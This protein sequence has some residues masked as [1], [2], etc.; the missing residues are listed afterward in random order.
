MHYIKLLRPPTLDRPSVSNNSRQHPPASSTSSVLKISLAITTDLGDA[1]LS[2]TT[3][4]ELLVIGAYTTTDKDGKP[5]L[6]PI[7][8]T[9]P[10]ARSNNSPK[11]KPGLRALKFEV[12]IP[13]TP[14][15]ITTVQ[16]RPVSREITALGTTDI[17]PIQKNGK[18]RGLIMPAFCD[19]SP[20]SQSSGQQSVCFRS[21]RLP[22]DNGQAIQVEEDMGDSIARHI[23]D[24]GIATVSLLADLCL[25]PH[26]TQDVMTGLRELLLLQ[27]RQ[28]LNILEIGCGIG[29]LGIGMARVMGHPSFPGTTSAAP[30]H[31]IL[32]TDLPEAEE[33]ARGNIARQADH[34]EGG[35]EDRLD[36]EALDWEDGKDGNF[37][38]R[39]AKEKWD[40]VV[41]SDCTYN[42]DTLLPLV[43][44][45]S[46]VHKH[47]A[48]GGKSP[49]LFL[50]TKQRHSSE[51]EFYDLMAKE[52]WVIAE[53]AVLPLP[54]V[55]GEGKPIEVYLFERK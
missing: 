40:L 23:W 21:L 24:S 34:L 18:G 55:T 52:G 48:A 35:G 2:P 20:E 36:F 50:S 28:G 32:M 38:K 3:P 5:Q 25:S 13:V 1:Y 15:P 29:M 53:Q 16:I 46:A 45:L 6:V 7:N 12:P 10:L 11:W 43:K 17:F 47:S 51:R 8:L 26:P 22:G 49:K 44:T 33:R 42:T 30:Q 9:A 27:K 4:I 19:I 54:H 37:G 39:V 31:K 41:V 14:S